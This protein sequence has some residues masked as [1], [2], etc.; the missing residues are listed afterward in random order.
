MVYFDSVTLFKWIRYLKRVE[1]FLQNIPLSLFSFLSRRQARRDNN[2]KNTKSQTR[3][4]H[5][6]CNRQTTK[7]RSKHSKNARPRSAGAK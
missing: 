1:L 3:P 5:N 4:C 2:K 6:V 7:D